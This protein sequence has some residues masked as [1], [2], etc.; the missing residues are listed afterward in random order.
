MAE[1]DTGIDVKSSE[2]T[3]MIQTLQVPWDKSLDRFLEQSDRKKGLSK[4]VL[5][6]IY[7]QKWFKMF[8]PKEH[9]GLAL[10]LLEGVRLQESLAAIDGSL[11]WTVTLCSGAN[12]FVGFLKD[13][14]V[15]HSF[16][17]PETCWGGS[18]MA[19]GWAQ[20]HESGYI[21]NGQ[22]KYATGAPHLTAFTV[23][24]QLRDERNTL[25]LANGEPVIKS[26]YLLPSEV[27][28]F[29]DW[30]AI[31]L[32]A[33]TSHRFEVKHQWVPSNRAF[34]LTPLHIAHPDPI[35]HLSFLTF[36]EVTLVGNYMGM[37]THFL[38]AIERS[39]IESEA[40]TPVDTLHS[41]RK[42]K[43]RLMANR[44]HFYETLAQ[45]WQELSTEGMVLAQMEMEMQEA[46]IAVVQC[47][48][49]AIQD[50]F[51]TVGMMVVCSDTDLNKIWLDFNTAT[52]HKLI[53][54]LLLS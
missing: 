27:S 9:G 4:E 34:E 43:A 25:I 13:P 51:P 12:W 37:A 23:N 19:T 45:L 38:E 42:I 50:V 35:Y 17:R 47:C 49:K 41:I 14:L 5:E 2:L 31:G 11:G 53:R 18:G 30:N 46:C 24:C 40:L 32:A 8:V 20:A 28:V 44:T 15:I 33:T 3:S 36:A 29:P 1:T 21:I 7:R 22:W 48:Y 16:D 10:S 54:S 39:I 26:F 6:H 52:Q